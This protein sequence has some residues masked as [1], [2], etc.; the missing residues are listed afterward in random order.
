MRS[1][2]DYYRQIEK[3]N[4]Y[5]CNPDQTPICTILGENRHI[6]LR[7]NDLSELT[8]TVSEI[9]NV[10]NSYNLLETK[11]L[12][13]VE[14]IGWFQITN[15]SETIDG[16]RKS[17]DVT[18][19]SHQTALKSK[20]FITEE[21]VYMFY[22]PND[23]L[24][25]HYD[26]LNTAAMPS[27][28]GQLYQQLGLKIKLQASDNEVDTDYGTWTLVYID[29]SLKFIAR[30]YNDQYISADGANNICR[31][32][33]ENSTYGY[34]FIINEVENA[35]E[36]IFDFDILHHTIKVKT[37]EEIAEDTSI[38]LSL[39]NLVNSLNITEN[40]EN[41]VTVLTCNGGD[42][43]IR[44]VN[45][46]GTNYIVDFSYFKKRVS[47]DGEMPY[48]WMSE[49]L[50]SALDEWEIIWKDWQSDNQD[51]DGHTK[52]Y[53]TIVQELQWLYTDQAVVDERIQYANLKWSDLQ[54]ARDQYL[55]G[56]D[57]ANSG[58]GI[59]SA[60]VISLKYICADCGYEQ[61]VQVETCSR[62]GG[63]QIIKGSDYSLLG[64]SVYYNNA[65][66]EDAV[67]TAYTEPPEQDNY[68]FNF[69]NDGK[70]GTAKS[71]IEGFIEDKKNND[72]TWSESD[73]ST[74][75]LYFSD[76]STKTSY[77]KLTVSSV[78]GV[79][80]DSSGNIGDSGTVE[81]RNNTFVV[82]ASNNAFT[83]GQPD[84]TSISVLKANPY[85]VY[86][87]TKYKLVES[88]DGVIT[89]YC[90]FVSGFERF[91]TYYA[92]TG[93]NG[94]CVLWEKY[95]KT[96]SDDANGNLG[97][98]QNLQAKI[99]E[100]NAELTY[101]NE[102]CDVQKFI[103]KRGDSLYDE[104]S[105]YWIEGTY[106]NDNLSTFDSTTMAERIQ[107]AKEL[108]EVAQ[109]E[110]VRSAQPTFEMSVDSVNFLG[111]IEF[112]SFSN[113]LEFGRVITIEKDDNTHY[114]PAL[115]GMEY[116][117]ENIDTFTLNF[118]TAARLDE[119]SMTFADLMN[120]ASETSRT[121]SS[122][123]SNLLDYSRN[124]TQISD[125]LNEPLNRTLRAA[126]ADMS[127]QQFLIDSTGILGRRWAD[128]SKTS[129][130]DEQIRIIN[131]TLLFTDDN[132]KTPKLALG[133]IRD[134]EGNVLG[135]GL[136]A[137]V[138][139]GTMFIGESLKIENIDNSIRI[140]GNGI[141]IAKKKEN[142]AEPDEVVF[143]ASPSGDVYLKGIIH[144]QAGGTIGGFT[145]GE[146]TLES[147]EG[148]NKVGMCSNAEI[149]AAFWTGDN[150]STVAPFSVLHDGSLYSNKGTIGGLKLEK[151]TGV[152]SG[153]VEHSGTA[154]LEV[155]I[156]RG[157]PGYGD[158][159]TSWY[160]FAA[161]SVFSLADLGIVDQDAILG[162]FIV[163]EGTDNEW[164]SVTDLKTNSVQLT[165]GIKIK[166]SSMTFERTISADVTFK[167]YTPVA[168]STEYTTFYSIDK[169][170][171]IVTLLDSTMSSLSICN[172]DIQNLN[173]HK[174][175][176][177]HAIIGNL[178][179]S[180]G[181][182][183]CDGATINF[184]EN[185]ADNYT[186][187]IGYVGTSIIVYINPGV[188]P[189]DKTFSIKYKTE[190]DPIYKT[191]AIT[192]S[193]G[194]NFSKVDILSFEKI[195]EAKFIRG[196]NDSGEDYLAESFNFSVGE[197]K[198]AI[199]ISGASL[200]PSGYYN[201]TYKCF[202]GG[203]LGFSDNRWS[204][205]Y[206]IQVGDATE[207]EE[208]YVVNLYAK[209]IYGTVTTT[210]DRNKK[211]TIAYLTA[212]TD[213]NIFDGLKPASFKFNNGTSGRTHYGFVAQDIKELLEQL[214]VDTQDFAAYCE[215]EEIDADGNKQTTCGIRYDEII[216]LCVYEIQKL[217]QE[218]KELK[219]NET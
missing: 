130:L 41:I 181:V 26:S 96:L 65:F 147:G 63:T 70:T 186:A 107:L 110:L 48:P 152:L 106:E 137:E 11:R 54:V 211:N 88:T 42:L 74:A 72:G 201:S 95:I 189:Y 198:R 156:P 85:F 29:P 60:E 172:T 182:I 25:E 99:D 38:Y 119:A 143:N 115:V 154:T 34:D 1:S 195:T 132:W 12:V 6:A 24:D 8:F 50:I 203:S 184:T 91:T 162:E 120:E 17:K 127:N 191:I 165:A 103:K 175:Q 141:I 66:T 56:D 125:L 52:G 114:R 171:N 213:K 167:Y 77:C 159:I 28:V 121:V 219:G 51:R 87:G 22:N 94:W 75:Y 67:I 140:D 176:A 79:V 160:V 117:L 146:H 193:G 216:P 102:Q 185:S 169:N 161:Y 183:S 128:S 20:G 19:E 157:T 134:E 168:S 153:V 109:K 197:Y 113:E 35:F 64:S 104:L 196:K 123:W 30:S 98:S 23:P 151:R 118:S 105:N 76:D 53:S 111:L 218:I 16:E 21:R 207:D 177:P 39:E 36:V 209:N 14:G 199:E 15:V 61:R 144:A 192:V 90:F 145:I 124:K 84:G 82:R 10:E 112:R 100:L 155:T 215:W 174:L 108:M 2:F 217:K 40:S 37:I 43:D 139:I 208:N 3:P 5:L 150:D 179:F 55:I 31:S 13:F 133:K 58:K 57:E 9:E 101:I 86:N 46:M 27:V 47:D 149:S 158:G 190:N 187:S 59:V 188:L 7:F 4:M 163:P 164:V 71:M 148:S 68:L 32:F 93:A 210:S 180:N 173:V 212:E 83:I 89:V 178:S 69:N 142:E 97:V 126:Q 45:P 135:Y 44:T 92:L 73:D 129:F 170:F 62:C 204:G 138:I 205:L 81:I 166:N 206:T 49:S 202:V 122:N 194:S 131:N 136:A 78:V 33:K 80:K 214:G 18:A 200:S 116:D